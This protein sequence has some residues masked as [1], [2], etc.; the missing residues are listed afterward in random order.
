[1]NCRI[2]LQM[3]RHLIKFGGVCVATMTANNLNSAWQWRKML[4]KEP[5]TTQYRLFA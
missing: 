3:M 1:M 4:T 2:S 5:K